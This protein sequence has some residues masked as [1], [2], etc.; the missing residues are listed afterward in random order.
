MKLNSLFT[1]LAAVIIL[2]SCRRENSLQQIPDIDQKNP[3][4]NPVN[5]DKNFKIVKGQTIYVPVYSY[6]Y[7]ADQKQTHHLT[8]TLSIRNTDLTQPIVITGVR[9][10]NSAGQLVRQYLERPIQLAALSSVHFVVDRSDN[11]GGLGAN[12]IVE[13]VAQTKAVSPIVEAVMIGSS[14]QQGISWISPGKV[15]KNRNAD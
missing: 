3:S 13:W 8:A 5:L 15:I 6:I 1:V 9:Y 12:F 14:F 7:H 10:N 2:T 4:V 11:S